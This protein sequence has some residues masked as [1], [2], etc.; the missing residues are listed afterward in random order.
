MAVI[1]DFADGNL[2]NFFVIEQLLERI[3]EQLF[4]MFAFYFYTSVLEISVQYIFYY[5]IKDSF[6]TIF[7]KCT[8]IRHLYKNVHFIKEEFL[9]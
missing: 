7:N 9:L 1:G 6:Y 5:I 4:C 8:K 2:I 3:G